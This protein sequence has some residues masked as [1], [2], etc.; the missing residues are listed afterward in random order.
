M[1]T[2]INIK[3]IYTK[4]QA[5]SIAQRYSSI[6]NNNVHSTIVFFASNL[7]ST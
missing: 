4:K 5:I 1:S 6:S 7:T 2:H 3:F